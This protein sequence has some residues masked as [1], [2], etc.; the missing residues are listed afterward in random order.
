ME[1]NYGTSPAADHIAVT[2]SS[3]LTL[4][5]GSLPGST[6][7]RLDAEVL[8]QYVLGVDRSW[9]HAH[10]DERLAAA[11]CCDF[12]ALVSRRREGVPVSYLVG[13]R[14][15][16]S[17]PLQVNRHTLIPRPETEALV[18]T[19][20]RLLQGRQG[21]RILDLGTGSGAI[22]LA[23]AC[24][25]PDLRITAADISREALEVARSNA[26]RLT[27]DRVEFVY[28]DWFSAFGPRR[29]DLIVCNPPYVD[30]GDPAL[31]RDDIRFEPRLALDGGH[32]GLQALQ[33][34]IAG[35][36]HHLKYGGSLLLEHGAAQGESVRRLLACRGYT[37]VTTIRDTADLERVSGGR[38]S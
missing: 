6:S 19:C 28:S 23:L 18:E 24:E 5:A 9:I 17:L 1:H 32:G 13:A 7:A 2:V 30:S 26:R 36:A 34:V 16:W 37:D 27:P 35:A 3:L 11:S 38:W 10:G 33:T 12:R 29:F 31:I 21:A 15:F 14:E 25:R 20:L 4:G 8:L 22:A